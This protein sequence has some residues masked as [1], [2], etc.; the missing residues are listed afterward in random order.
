LGLKGIEFNIGVI[1]S[2]MPSSI[3]SLALTI[4]YNLD[5]E[6]VA[7]CIFFSTIVSFIS[8][9]IIISLL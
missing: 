9:P 4:N 3:L 8:L 2:A 6:L 7:D 5:N 1:E